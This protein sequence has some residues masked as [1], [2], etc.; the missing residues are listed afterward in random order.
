MTTP[1]G[2]ARHEAFWVN[3]AGEPYAPEDAVAGEI[4][5]FDKDGLELGRTY[6]DRTFDTETVDHEGDPDYEAGW[7]YNNDWIKAGTWDLWVS[8]WS[9]TIDTLAEL[10][11]GQGWSQLP[12]REQRKQVAAM[13]ALPVWIPAPEQ[14]KTEV[15]AWLGAT[16]QE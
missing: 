1:L 9:K 6:F 7:V 12:L 10:L 3:A 15:L 16:V 11:D 14:L 5:E 13:M 8:D 2:G 4:R